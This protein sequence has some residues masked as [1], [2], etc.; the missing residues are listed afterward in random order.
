MEYVE[1]KAE[2]TPLEIGRDILIAELSEIGFESFVETDK[3]NVR[4]TWHLLSTF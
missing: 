1:F 3:K 2:I 4:L